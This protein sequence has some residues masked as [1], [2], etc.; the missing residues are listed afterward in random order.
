MAREI[1]GHAMPDPKVYVPTPQDP[2]PNQSGGTVPW[3]SQGGGSGPNQGPGFAFDAEQ[4]GRIAETWQGLAERFTDAERNASFLIEADGPGLEYAS[5]GN[6]EKVRSS[7]VALRE[8]LSQRAQYCRTM[9]E[10][11]REASGAYLNQE[12]EASTEIR[13]DGGKF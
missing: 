10:R 4:L 3:A 6:A 2:E 5:Q 8:T 13:S 7:G 1:R 9:A 11:F 12:D